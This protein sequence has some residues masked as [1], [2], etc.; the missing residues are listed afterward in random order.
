M[1]LHD[2]QLLQQIHGYPAVT[3]TIPTHRT[4]PDNRQDPIRLKN[5]VAQAANQ[6]LEE[7]SKRDIDPLLTRLHNLAENVDFNHAQDGLVLFANQDFGGVYTLP[8][9]LKE[10]VVIDQTFATR[11]LVFAL[12]RTPRYWVLVLSE[13]P[14]RLF[15]ATRDDLVEIQEDGFPMTHEGPGGSQA[16]PGGFGIQRSA[17]RD[18]RHLQFFRAVDNAL[19][20]FLADD[21]LPVVVV[22]VDHYLAFFNEVTNYK[23]AILTTVQGNYD[24]ETPSELSKLVWPPAK[25]ALAEKRQ[26]Y[27]EQLDAA[28]GAQRVASTVGE[29]WRFAHEGRGSLLLVEEDFHFHGKLDATG[30][31]LLP[32][33]AE[34]SIAGIETIADAVDDIIEIVLSKQGQVVFVDNGQLEKYQRIAL[35]LRY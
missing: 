7:F 35:I 3:I 15:E 34:E 23:D 26:Q 2:V 6:L 20:P 8:F 25:A 13:K 27:L 31:N 14:T 33:T 22:G 16:L 17:Y 24:K 30:A 19:K 5:L 29:V 1:N 32:A 11:D 18:E 12:N 9:D 28:S 10:R 21:P 4:S